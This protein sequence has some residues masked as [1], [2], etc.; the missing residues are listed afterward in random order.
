MSQSQLLELPTDLIR[1]ALRETL[2]KKLKST[3][4]QIDVSSVSE[5]GEN[6]F[7]GEI[8]RASFN[9]K[10]GDESKSCK[11]QT[12]K[13]FI[14]TAPQDV[15]FRDRCFSRPSFLREIYIYDEV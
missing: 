1:S 7:M 3:D 8:Y 12:H 2:E 11:D 4:Y 5:V 14:K 6:N 15:L 10:S 9:K 13:L